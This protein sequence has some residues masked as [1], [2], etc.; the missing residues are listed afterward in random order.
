MF[1]SFPMSMVLLHGARAYR[2]AGQNKVAGAGYAG[3]LLTT[4]TLG[5]MTAI[6]LKDLAAGRDPRP[7]GD[8]PGEILQF[9]AAA[10]LQGGGLGIFG[11]FFFSDINRFGGG[12]GQTLTGPM[13]ERFSNAWNLTGGNLVQLATGGDTNFAEEARK[14]MASNIPGSSLWY[15]K[16]GYQRALMDQLQ[17]HTDPK[18]NT[19]FK[20]RQANQLRTYGNGYWWQPGKLMPSR[21]PKF[22]MNRVSR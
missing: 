17:F 19:S 10:L 18:A 16:L 22:E 21:A 5:G 9:G 2:L 12:F 13:I 11:D 4:A 7:I 8:D 15:L 6:W 20:R 3:A 1:K 14:F